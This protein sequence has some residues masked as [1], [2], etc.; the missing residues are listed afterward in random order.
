MKDTQLLPYLT[1]DGTCREA[2]EFYKQVLGGDLDVRY[3]KEFYGDLPPADREKVMHAELKNDA[4]SLMASDTVP[5]SKTTF[6]DNVRI[7]LTGND[8]PRLAAFFDRLS[9]GGTVMMPF[10]KQVWGQELGMLTDKFGTHW[11]VSVRGD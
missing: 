8:S 4:M 2:M 6:G 5:G 1:F 11:L 10:E 7:T 3:F 9:R